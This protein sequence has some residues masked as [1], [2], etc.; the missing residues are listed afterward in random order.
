MA[1]R[2]NLTDT[3]TAVCAALILLAAASVSGTE[4]PRVNV[5]TADAAAIASRLTGVGKKKAEAIVAYREANGR[6]D[7]PAD[8]TKVK[9]IG[10][11]IVEK[12]AGR[13]VVSEAGGSRGGASP[14]AS[15]R[16][17]VASGGD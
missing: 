14:S 10:P 11:S 12:N 13:I 5:N 8:L 9:G 17:S 3:L 7:A 1:W 16:S 2:K 6:F 15:Q 4:S